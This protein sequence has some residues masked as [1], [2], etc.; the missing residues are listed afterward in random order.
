MEVL[1]CKDLLLNIAKFLK[2]EDV[3]CLEYSG[4]GVREAVVEGAVWQ[5]VA[6]GDERAVVLLKY[7]KYW[8]TMCLKSIPLKECLRPMTNFSRDR[9]APIEV[10]EISQSVVRI[11][12]VMLARDCFSKLLRNVP[13]V[14]PRIP[15]PHLPA[16]FISPL[17]LC[18]VNT[19]KHP[20]VP[21]GHV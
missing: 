16:S 1:Q 2:P 21:P 7:P 20:P 17:R 9:V 19:P 12:Y 10:W 3:A 6:E 5:V 8:K 14:P 11:R 15:S 4:M 18:R 13:P